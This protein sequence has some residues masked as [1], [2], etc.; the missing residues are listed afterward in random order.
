MRLER[1]TKDIE[2]RNRGWELSKTLS[3]ENV[4]A[5]WTFSNRVPGYITHFQKI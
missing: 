2:N 3:M 4:N 1:V 5:L